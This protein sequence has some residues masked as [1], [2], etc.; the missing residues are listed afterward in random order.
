MRGR[1]LKLTVALCGLGAGAVY[2]ADQAAQPPQPDINQ[3]IV[4]QMVNEGQVANAA[5]N[6]P[7]ENPYTVQQMLILAPK[8]TADMQ[9]AIEH[10]Q[11]VRVMAYRSHDIIRMTCIDDK[12]NQMKTLVNMAST[13]MLMLRTF[14]DQPIVMREQFDVI[15]RAHDR[16]SQLGAEVDACMGDN[17]EAVSTGKIQEEQEPTNV[18]DPTRP[19][20]PTTPIE[21][22]PEAS[23]YN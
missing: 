2:A 18:N 5:P 10:A 19:P 23:P 16:V 4:Q 11:D 17:L 20:S 1:T 9:T 13:P 12:V 21:R 8:Y 15:G 6:A 7:A 22:P 14:K 3:T